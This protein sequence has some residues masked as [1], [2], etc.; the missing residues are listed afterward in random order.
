MLQYNLL[1]TTVTPRYLKQII[2][3]SKISSPVSAGIW[4]RIFYHFSCLTMNSSLCLIRNLAV[5][6]DYHLSS[7][8]DGIIVRKPFYGVCE[9]VRA[10]V[11]TLVCVCGCAH[12]M[13]HVLRSEKTFSIF[14]KVP[15]LFLPLHTEG[16]LSHDL[17]RIILSLPPLS[18]QEQCIYRP[19]LS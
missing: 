3:R 17:P 8:N 2:S 16:Q 12:A 4:Q 13:V 11:C 5:C 19:L 18:L 15:L 10:H 6:H 14:T 1:L 7:C 9:H